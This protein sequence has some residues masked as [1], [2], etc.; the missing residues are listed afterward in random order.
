MKESR[1]F[2]IAILFAAL[3]C[4]FAGGCD[5]LNPWDHYEARATGIVVSL[6]VH[7][8]E[9][10]ATGEWEWRSYQ[11]GRHYS[12]RPVYVLFEAYDESEN[13]RYSSGGTF[14]DLQWGLAAQIE[15][16]DS[17]IRFALIRPSGRWNFRGTLRSR[18]AEGS[19][20]FEPDVSFVDEV[21][22]VCGERPNIG[23]LI[24]LGISGIPLDSLRRFKSAVQSLDIQGWM[25]L[26]NYGVKP[27][28]AESMA[29]AMG[30]LATDA[31]IECHNYGVTPAFAAGYFGA[32]Y[33][34]THKDLI[35]L[36]NYGVPVEF[37]AELKR[38]GMS[39]N[40]EQLVQLRN[41]GVQPSYA[42]RVK[43]LGYGNNI[44]D[45][46]QMRNY[47]VPEDFISETRD[48]GYQL[49]KSEIIQLRNYGVPPGFLKSVKKM[50]YSF[51]I[52]QI[53]QLRNCGVSESYLAEIMQNG[54]K[55]L[56]ADVIIDLHSRGVP[57]ETVRAIR[58]Q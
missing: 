6:Q 11:E 50:G 43:D 19:V 3:L 27:E 55:P 1:R 57:A 58:N 18:G 8:G 10:N 7:G 39:L 45:I 23:E 35:Q 54:R 17:P 2:R 47:G 56:S 20:E 28:Y 31:L 29:S 36:K 42:L 21:S 33:I 26:V 4:V 22:A 5:H 38:G 44:E 13:H 16:D 46:I 52:D 12:G 49:S 25:K 24:Q 9:T 34:F 14:S 41:Y 15:K 37:A 48:S 30:K 32:G 40:A 53:V 51:S